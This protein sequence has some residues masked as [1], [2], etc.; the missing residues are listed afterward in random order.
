MARV[1]GA[2]MPFSIWGEL[3]IHKL[4]Y[5]KRLNLYWHNQFI[6]FYSQRKICHFSVIWIS[7]VYLRCPV[8]YS[9]IMLKSVRIYLYRSDESLRFRIRPSSRLFNIYYSLPYNNYSFIKL[10]PSVWTCFISY[11]AVNYIA[12]VMIFIQFNRCFLAFNISSPP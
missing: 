1:Q 9:I 8:I 2:S 3:T 5:G 11:V 6:S 4:G 7:V 12:C 10:Y